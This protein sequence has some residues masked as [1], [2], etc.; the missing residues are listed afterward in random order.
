MEQARPFLKIAREVNHNVRFRF[1]FFARK[2]V[3]KDGMFLENFFAHC[4]VF[5]EGEK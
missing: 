3:L 5:L 4:D 1:A 2:Y